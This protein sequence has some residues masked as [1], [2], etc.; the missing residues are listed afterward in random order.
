MF[1]YFIDVIGAR[2]GA[3]LSFPYVSDRELVANEVIYDS[4]GRGYVVVSVS[5]DT[6][7]DPKHGDVTLGSATAKRA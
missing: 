5:E 4:Q 7:P 2:G 1:R 3:D 6:L